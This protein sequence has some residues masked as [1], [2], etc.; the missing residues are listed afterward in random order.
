MSTVNSLSIRLEF[1]QGQWV[2]EE[3]AKESTLEHW[4]TTSSLR[5]QLKWFWP[6]QRKIQWPQKKLRDSKSGTRKETTKHQHWKKNINGDPLTTLTWVDCSTKSV[7]T[8]V[9]SQVL[10]DRV[11]RPFRDCG[12]SLVRLPMEKA[13]QANQ[14]TTKSG[15]VVILSGFVGAL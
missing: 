11:D 15:R 7:A 4:K 5:V 10:S 1:L 14:K 2:L 9:K 13:K 12:F 8:C 6:T 3:D